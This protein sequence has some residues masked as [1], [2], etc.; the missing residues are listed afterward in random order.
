VD[1]R[2]E[3][4][5]ALHTPTLYDPGGL[6]FRRADRR[7]TRCLGDRRSCERYK[8]CRRDL[9]RVVRLQ[10]VGVAVVRV[11]RAWPVSGGE[12][13]D[14]ATD[15]ADWVAVTV[16]FRSPG[17]ATYF[18]VRWST[19]D[20]ELRK[21]ETS[22]AGVRLRVAQVARRERFGI[23]CATRLDR[24]CIGVCG[25][26]VAQVALFPYESTVDRL[27]KKIC[28]FCVMTL[29]AKL[30]GTSATC[31]TCATRSLRRSVQPRS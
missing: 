12:R 1:L 19:P 11:A 2:A 27:V 20:L 17:G 9:S 6:R 25:L 31:A 29:H 24:G 7:K 10:R 5:R 15:A 22:S 14:G 21:T 4:A 28:P 26:R 18:V 30:F 13:R 16:R 23:P 8:L 3:P